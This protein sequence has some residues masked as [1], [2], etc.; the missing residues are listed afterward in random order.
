M[1]SLAGFGAAPQEGPGAERRFSALAFTSF[2]QDFLLPVW[3]LLLYDET[4]EQKG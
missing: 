2:A 4:N 3:T 1:K